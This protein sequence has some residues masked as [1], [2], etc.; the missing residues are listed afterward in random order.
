M[1]QGY[2]FAEAGQKIARN[3]RAT[4]GSARVGQRVTR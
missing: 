4:Q 2:T 3:S 1:S